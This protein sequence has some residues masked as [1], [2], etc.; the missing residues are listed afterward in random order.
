MK[1]ILVITHDTSL[2]GAPKSLVLTLESLVKR[3]YLFTVIA[4][5]GGGGLENRFKSC[6]QQYYRL[7]ELARVPSYTFF[8]R[9]KHKVLGEKILSEYDQILE[10]I[11]TNSYLCMY[12]NTVVSL[13]LALQLN[14][15]LNRNLIL[16]V[17]ELATVINEFYPNL[18]GTV[19]EVSRY[20]VPSYLNKQ[21]LI[22]EFSIPENVISVIR[23]ASDFMYKQLTPTSSHINVLM[24]GGAYWRKGD[25]LF[26]QIAKKLVEKDSNFKF[27]W[28]GHSSEERLRVNTSDCIKLGLQDHVFFIG[29]TTTPE[30]WYAK[31]DIFLLSSREDPFP[32]AAIEAGMAGLPIFCFEK[33]TGIAEL[34]SSTCVVP[35]LDVDQMATTIYQKTRDKVQLATIG[36]AN[37]KTF[38]TFTGENISNEIEVLL[39]KSYDRT[40]D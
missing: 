4:L 28:V 5:K 27:Y 11:S 12:V 37:R 38:S 8:S 15:K 14:K 20:I 34:I 1:S 13:P 24:C 26:L 31:S 39:E 25:D 18:T 40:I 22:T 19:E 32:L 17:H 7:D 21:C 2:S 36:E 10:K 16:H 30:Q 35:Y 9:L 23:E 33:A 29:E 3:G 6:A